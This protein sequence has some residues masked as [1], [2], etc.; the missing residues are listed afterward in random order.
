[1]RLDV[2]GTIDANG[3]L[4]LNDRQSMEAWV[5]QHANHNITLSIDVRK[6]KRSNH[7]NAYYWSIVVP[8]IK[9]A[10]IALGHTVTLEESHEML[11]ARF[12]YKEIVNEETGEVVQ[13]PLSTTKLNTVD[14][15]EYIER[16]QHFAAQFLNINIPSPN[17]QASI[18]T[19]TYDKEVKA[20]IIQ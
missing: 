16:I 6:K 20:I 17:E 1:M 7:Q 4:L 15:C 18:F 9:D 2:N 11:K 5:K 3:K 13:L 19:A 8:M 12:N 10:L 14:F